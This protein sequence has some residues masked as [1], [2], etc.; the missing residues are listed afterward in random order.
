MN[1]LVTICARAG[2]KGV[3]S[4]N[5]RELN[6]EPLAW[7]TLR[8]YR[9]FREGTQAAVD[10]A[11]NTD[12]PVLIEQAQAF[13]EA[14][15]EIPREEALAGDRVGKVAVIQDTLRKMEARCGKRYDCVIDLDL[16]SPLRRPGDI[17]GVLRTL[18]EDPAA[19]VAISV[20]PSRRSPYFNMVK[21]GED[22]YGRLVLESDYLARQEAPECFDINGSIYVYRRGFLLRGVKKV[23]DG[24]VL[25]YEMPDYGVLD[26]DSEDDYKLMQ[27]IAAAIEEGRL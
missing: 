16:T 26:I 1:I 23:L 25:F 7:R 22:G 27:I 24:K 2:S 19:D 6:G 21:R 11:V 18:E 13:G 8:A 10:L 4:K 14:F 15:Q 12:S 9:K 5:I 20:V 3:K 17:E